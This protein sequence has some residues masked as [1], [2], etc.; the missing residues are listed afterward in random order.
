[1]DIEEI[2]KNAKSDP[3][4]LSNINV[5]ELL[6]AIDSE[7]TDYLEN[8]T[9]KSISNEIFESLVEIGCSSKTIKNY[10]EK[11]IG[12]RLVNKIYE[13]HKGKLVKTIKIVD[14]KTPETKPEPKIRMHGTVSNIK[15]L[16]NGT[17]VVCMVFP[18][19]YSQYKFDNHL[20]FQKLS[21]D[22]Q[23]ILMA[24]EQIDGQMKK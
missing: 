12:Y 3:E 11:L 13:L 9:L 20:T 8:K 7:K 19:R 4:L 1:M 22:E 17:H 15:F 21:D 2:F 23:L 16:D 24:Y 5:D 6:N 18:Q 14:E 10:C